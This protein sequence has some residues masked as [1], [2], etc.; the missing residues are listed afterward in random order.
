MICK[1]Q[2]ILCLYLMN[3]YGVFSVLSVMKK[4]KKN[5][6]SQKRQE[7]MLDKGSPPDHAASAS[8]FLF[9]IQMHFFPSFF[10]ICLLVNAAIS[11]CQVLWKKMT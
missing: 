6:F 10:P 1:D 9:F 4:K 3:N 2:F 11:S 7:N 5:V 8:K